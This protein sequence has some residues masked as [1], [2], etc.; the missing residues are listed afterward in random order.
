MTKLTRMEREALDNLF[1][2]LPVHK[3]S[4]IARIRRLFRRYF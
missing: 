3:E 1:M 2:G 4:L